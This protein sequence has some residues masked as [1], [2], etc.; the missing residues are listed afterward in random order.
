M[1]LGTSEY[2]EILRDEYIQVA[3]ICA[4]NLGM[5]FDPIDDDTIDRLLTE[6]YLKDQAHAL[7]FRAI[8]GFHQKTLCSLLR[9]TNRKDHQ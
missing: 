8:R 5:N 3:R 7:L 2:A 6:T 1:P 4:E 9:T